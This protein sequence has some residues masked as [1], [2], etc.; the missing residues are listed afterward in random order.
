V[1]A[2]ILAGGF[3]TRLSEETNSRP[4]PMIEIGGKPILWHIMNIYAV[5]GVTEFIIAAGYKAEVIKEYFLNFYA[6][7]NDITIDLATG[8]TIIHSG[9]QPNWKIHIVDTGLYTQTGGRLRRL[10]KWVEKEKT[11]MF[12]YGDGVADININE[13]LA[14]HKSHGKL[15]TVTTVR[16]PARF[17]RIA[18]EQ[19]RI[20]E[21]YEKPETGEGWISG[22]FFVLNPKVIDYIENDGIVWER[23]PVEQLVREEQIMGYRHYSFWS[24]MDT[25]KEKNILEELWNSGKAPWKIW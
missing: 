22:G 5:H 25:L 23:D 7:N 9:N 19:D 17:G 15:A 18:F 6:I 12:T 1:K 13:L 24:C 8:N 2:I 3:G 16:S 14:F 20:T 11:F 4:K 10:R 21:F